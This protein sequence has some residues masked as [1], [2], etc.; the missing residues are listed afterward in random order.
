MVESRGCCRDY[1]IEVPLLFVQSCAGSVCP[2]NIEHEVLDLILEPLLRL[3]KGSAFGVHG[4]YMFLS[5]LQPLGQLLPWRLCMFV[6]RSEPN[7]ELWTITMLKSMGNFI[8]K[9]SIHSLN[10]YWWA[11][12]MNQML[13]TQ[14]W[15]G[16][17]R[18]LPH[19]AS[20]QV[21]NNKQVRKRITTYCRY[22]C[23]E[24]K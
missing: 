20:K 17:K 22:K 11:A 2:L 16:Q 19:E 7:Q 13:S 14:Q 8:L 21:R 3:L 24:G 10:K 18:S 6:E 15:T 23:S 1:L 5:S 9:I 4:F 12:F